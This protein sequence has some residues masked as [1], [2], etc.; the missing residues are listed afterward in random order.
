ML[1]LAVAMNFTHFA[2]IKI[3]SVTEFIH[4]DQREEKLGLTPPP[5]IIQ[6]F[7]KCTR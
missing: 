4:Y 2:Y 3:L 5:P 1:F 6:L 7:S